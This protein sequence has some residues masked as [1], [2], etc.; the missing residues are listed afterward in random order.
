MSDKYPGGFVTA[1]A[2]AGFSVAFDGTGDYLTVPYNSAFAL[3][4]GS[5]TVEAW[6]YKLNTNIAGIVA[7]LNGS[8]GYTFRVNANGTV[9]FFYVGSSSVTT[10]ST[11]STNT[12]THLAAVRNGTTV[13]IYINGVAGGSSTFST[14][15]DPSSSLVIGVNVPWVVL[16]FLVIVKLFVELSKNVL[17]CAPLVPLPCS[18]SVV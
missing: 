13:T 16:P 18:I 14:E 7:T 4:T 11:V 6:V 12:W 5:S 1:N 10:T 2:P 9:Q 8:T 17:F 15:T 3:G